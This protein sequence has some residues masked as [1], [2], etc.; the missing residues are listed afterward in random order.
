[1]KQKKNCPICQTRITCQNGSIALDNFI[2]RMVENQS[3]EMKNRR[4]EVVEERKVQELLGPESKPGPS[5]E[6]QRRHR[7]RRSTTSSDGPEDD[8]KKRSLGQMIS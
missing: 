3:V 5:H 1:M 7:R 2:D 8:R 6:P 4:Q